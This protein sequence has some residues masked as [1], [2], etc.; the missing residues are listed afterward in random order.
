[1]DRIVEFKCVVKYTALEIK[2]NIS[3]KLLNVLIFTRIDV[4]FDAFSVLWVD[5]EQDE[6][7][8][9]KPYAGSCYLNA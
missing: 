6:Q 2:C 5:F 9:T 4:E 3:R 1:M 8:S 7:I